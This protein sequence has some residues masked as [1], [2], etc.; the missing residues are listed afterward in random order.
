ML[1]DAVLNRSERKKTEILT[2]ARGVFLREGY[3]AAGM[4][5]VARMAGVSTA[6]LYAYFPS[7]AKLF[8]I[9]VH[10]AVGRMAEPVRESVQAIGDARARLTSLALAYATF[11]SQPA[12]RAMF[13][14]VA[15]ERRRFET[16]ADH[17]LRAAHQDLGGAAITLIQDLV[18][19]GE[20]AVDQP[21]WAGG[22]LLGMLD[23]ATLV[24]GLAAGDE[25]QPARPLGE[26][27]ADAVETFLARYGVEPR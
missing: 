14:M 23:H 3:A 21:A 2:A 16:V 22:Q 17:V 10:D 7:K 15:S 20:L 27:C 4:E 1:I 19:T 18:E 26:I 13:R 6:T 11:M 9:V 24:L 8:E 12:T 25:A 5:V